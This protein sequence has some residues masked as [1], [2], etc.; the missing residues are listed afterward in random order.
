MKVLSQHCLAGLFLCAIGSVCAGP[1]LGQNAADSSDPANDANN[2]QGN[3]EVVELFESDDDDDATQQRIEVGSFGQIDL[4]VKDLDVT[5][6]LRLLSMQSK[7]NI[8]ASRNVSGKVSAN[9]YGVDFYE[10]LDAILQPNG[11]GYREKGDFIYVYT[12]DELDEIEKA[13]RKRITKVVRVNYLNAADAKVLITPM[14]SEDGETVISSE[15]SQ[16]FQPSISDG[17]ADSYAGT[18]TIVLTDYEENVAEAISLIKELDTRPQQVLI[19]ATILQARL[20]ED[21]A[22]G[23]DFS[24][25][26]NVDLDTFADPL[27]AVDD[28]IKGD[29]TDRSAGVQSTVGNTAGSSGV[30][31]GFLGSHFATF[32]RALDQVTDTTVLSVPKI[33]TLNRQKAELLVGNRLGYLNTTVTETSRTQTVEFLE[34]GTELT[35][36]PFVSDDGFIRLELRP[37][38]STGDTSRETADG[39]IIPDEITQELVTNVIVRSGQTLVLGGLFTEDTSINRNQIPG[40]G[41]IPIAG[42][43]FKGQND[44]VTRSEIIFLIKPTVIKDNSLYAAGERMTDEIADLRAGMR[45]GLLPWSR[46]KL[47]QSHMKRALELLEEGRQDKALWNI[48]LVLAMNPTATDALELRSRLTGEQ[49]FLRDSSIWTRA[50][51]NNIAEQ[52]QELIES[53]EELEIEVPTAPEDPAPEPD[54]AM[55]PLE[56]AM[57]DAAGTTEENAA[58]AAANDATEPRAEGDVETSAEAADVETGIASAVE[59]VEEPDIVVIEVV[60]EEAAD[61]LA[62]DASTE[63][64]ST[65]SQADPRTEELEVTEGEESGEPSAAADMVIEEYVPEEFAVESDSSPATDSLD[66]QYIEQAI[67]AAGTEPATQASAD[68]LDANAGTVNVLEVIENALPSAFPRETLTEV[69]TD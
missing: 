47:T 25:F 48:N 51:S 50:A 33:L 21:N 12:R 42:A 65:Q 22:F 66:E 44:G 62:E 46:T 69:A 61:E 64:A 67:E 6:V 68:P 16:G 3:G 63:S 2:E 54:E 57:S 29:V 32:V 11:F 19:E 30:K 18:P 34:D 60:G 10:A 1:A 41:D 36:R 43:A 31:I 59:P 45:Q 26:A 49:I 23:V 28:L 20:T 55:D 56:D 9:L 27:N 8:I 24:V 40:L 4:Q 52:M 35:V 38:V 13:D 17:G 14:L 5:D 7:K 58:D 37:S 39:Q 53:A 15:T